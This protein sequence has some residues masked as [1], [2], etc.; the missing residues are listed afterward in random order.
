[1]VSED[2]CR[3]GNRIFQ[4]SGSTDGKCGVICG[5][6]HGNRTGSRLMERT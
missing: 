4:Y 2:R 5:S 3:V 6:V 1:M